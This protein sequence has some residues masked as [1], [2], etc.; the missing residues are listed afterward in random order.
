MLRQWRFKILRKFARDGEELFF[1]RKQR[2]LRRLKPRPFGLFLYKP[3][4]RRYDYVDYT[5]KV[6]KMETDVGEATMFLE[7]AGYIKFIEKE[8]CNEHFFK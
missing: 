1:G 7:M 2:E 8:D 6:G 4:R 5:G 3:S